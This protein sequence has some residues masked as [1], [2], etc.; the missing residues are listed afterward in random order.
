M[1][2]FGHLPD[3]R[4]V[5]RVRI[6]GGG[7]TAAFLTWGA[8][9]QDLRLDGV[10]FPLVL[11]SD[12]FEPYLGSLLYSG[13]LVGRFANRIGK[14]GF[15]IDGTAFQADRNFLGR[16]T[17]HGG[18][19]GS[20]QMLWMLADH[21]QDCVS[22]ALQLTDMHMGFPGDMEVV[23]KF[24]LPGDGVLA[25]EVIATCNRSTPCNFA[26]HSYFNLDDS[27]SATEHRLQIMAESYLPVDGEMIPTGEIAPV[28]G[29]RFDFRLPRPVGDAGYDHNFCTAGIRT[30]LRPVAVLDSPASGI[31]LTVEST[32]P[33]LQFYDG[34]HLDV[35]DGLSGRL[36]GSKSGI[37]LEAQAWPDA[38]NMA[39]APDAILRPGETY[40]QSLRYVF[41][42][43]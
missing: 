9:L 35:R 42:S 5:E 26:Q 34:A 17:L 22:F 33:G 2:T 15:E 1:E 37:A 25:L 3:G 39:G 27:A 4:T 8:T 43:S 30:G 20:G 38:P 11:G 19:E 16:H 41:R 36:C 40:H 10:P 13:A 14:G 28:A 32:E 29:T 12:R 21:G 18:A 31:S 7:L 24:S 23:A 6:S